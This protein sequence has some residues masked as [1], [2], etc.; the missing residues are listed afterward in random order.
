MSALSATEPGATEPPAPEPDAAAPGDTESGGIR[1][2]ESGVAVPVAVGVVVAAVVA[3]LALVGLVVSVTTDRLPT[4]PALP[5]PPAPTESVTWDQRTR[6]ARFGAVSATM[7][8]EPY[9][10][11]SSLSS[12]P[13]VLNDTVICDVVVHADYDG[14]SDWSAT[15]GFG[16]VPGEHVGPT[17]E[18]TAKALFAS[19]REAAF[20]GQATTEK[21]VEVQ[22]VTLSG[23]PV[24]AVSAEVHYQ[25]A[26]LPSTYDRVLVIVVP[27]DDD[28]YAAY[29][30][31]R[32][33]DLPAATLATLN[34]SIDKLR[35]S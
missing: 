13:G 5:P 8:A 1:S 15:A 27:V 17:A 14:S 22:Q 34:A 11:P 4:G 18:A 10:C 28:S 7:P 3:V 26:N 12:L 23:Q 24:V 19:I 2:P 30:S 33:N 9:A 32:P 35:V 31:S 6:E 25:V 21:N 16:A 29:F 20:S